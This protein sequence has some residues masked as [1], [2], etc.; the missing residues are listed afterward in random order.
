MGLTLAAHLRQRSRA[1]LEAFLSA[2][3]EDLG[4]RSTLDVDRLLED[5]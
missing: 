3:V 2:H 4:Q 5:V 1:D